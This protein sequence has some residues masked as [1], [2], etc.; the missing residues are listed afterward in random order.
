MGV[1]KLLH[2]RVEKML[3]KQDQKKNK[4]SGIAVMSYMRRKCKVGQV[5]E[6]HS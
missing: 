1:R 2:V 6:L 5:V 3:P 4:C